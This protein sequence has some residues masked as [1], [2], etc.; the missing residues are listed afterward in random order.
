M[1]FTTVVALVGIA[2]AAGVSSAELGHGRSEL[3]S[4]LGSAALRLRLRLRLPLSS[5][6]ALSA[7]RPSFVDER[8]ARPGI[9]GDIAELARITFAAV[10]REELTNRAALLALSLGRGPR[11]SAVAWSTAA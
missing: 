9:A 11:I 5:R 8:A 7:T 2:R 10:P 1:R 3:G 4:G 6:A